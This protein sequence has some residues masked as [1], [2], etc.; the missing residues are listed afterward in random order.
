[1]KVGDLILFYHSSCPIPGIAGI[2]KV[3]SKPYPD[4]TQFEKISEYNIRDKASLPKDFYSKV[5]IRC[6][7]SDTDLQWNV[8]ENIGLHT[9]IWQMENQLLS[10]ERTYVLEK[11]RKKLEYYV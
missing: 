9:Y 7:V 5:N 4:S 8:P 10:N 11:L 3:G 6:I 1:M 2:A